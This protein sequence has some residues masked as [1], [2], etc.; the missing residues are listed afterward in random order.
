MRRL[1]DRLPAVA[2]EESIYRI[3]TE[4]SGWV[5][6]DGTISSGAF[7]FE[8][9]SAEIASRVTRPEDS[10]SRV[11]GACAVIVFNCGCARGVGFDTRDERDD[12]HPDNIAHVHV[13]V[14]GTRSDRKRRVRDFMTVCKP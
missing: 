9:F 8:Y 12:A 5:A 4:R 10:L 7:C 2:G 1:E 13:Y 3:A 11:P 6:T 14:D